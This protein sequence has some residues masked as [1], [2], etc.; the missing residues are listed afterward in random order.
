MEFDLAETLAA[1]RTDLSTAVQAASDSDLQ[2]PV[3]TVQ[4][5]LT[6]VAKRAGDARA[7]VRFWVVDAGSSASMAR[8]QT[9]RIVV[10]LGPPTDENGAPV[11]VRR[12]LA[13]RP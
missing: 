10:N 7:G 9:H 8:E 2:F 6:V 3:E 11:R 12:R 1:L 5:E 13:D 4:V